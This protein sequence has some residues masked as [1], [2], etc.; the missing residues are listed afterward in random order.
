MTEEETK[1]EIN[2]FLAEDLAKLANLKL[3]K[4]A[5]EKDIEDL[6]QQVVKEMQ[7]DHL[8]EA[9]FTDRLGKP[10][11]ATVVTGMIENIDLE[12]LTNEDPALAEA[13]TDRKVNTAKLKKAKD[14]GLFTNPKAAKALVYKPRK[15]YILITALEEE[16]ADE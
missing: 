3:L 7:T 11:K 8:R 13:I 5:I 10:A 9:E 14:L 16:T 12:Y 1:P 2:Q 15:P 6:Q 4:A